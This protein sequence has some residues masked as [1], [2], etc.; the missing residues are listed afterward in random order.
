MRR[1]PPHYLLLIILTSWSRSGSAPNSS[2]SQS[3]LRPKILTC[4]CLDLGVGALS[5][6][7]RLGPWDILILILNTWTILNCY[8]LA[9]C[10][11]SHLGKTVL[12]TFCELFFLW[13]CES[14]HVKV[15]KVLFS[16]THVLPILLHR[17]RSSILQALRRW[18][19]EFKVTQISSLKV[20][21]LLVLLFPQFLLLIQSDPLLTFKSPLLE[22]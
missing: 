2:I 11:T 22:L 12:C 19:D 10:R 7:L 6:L 8:R 4:A 5:R 1:I 16:H 20:V 9:N 14:T 15:F 3:R 17:V 13:T 21:P 18:K